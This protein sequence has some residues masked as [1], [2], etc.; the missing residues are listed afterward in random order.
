[1]PSVPQ[2]VGNAFNLI[3]KVDFCNPNKVSNYRARNPRCTVK[4][5]KY[6]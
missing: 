5:C 3:E 6:K 4:Y 1:M 2:P